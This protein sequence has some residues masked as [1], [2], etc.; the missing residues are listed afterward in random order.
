MRS[1]FLTG[2]SGVGKSTL[3]I[4]ALSQMYQKKH[5]PISGYLTYRCFLKEAV[6]GY[7]IYS[8]SKYIET[9]NPLYPL[10]IR[11]RET[12]ELEEREKYM[13]FQIH[14][15]GVHFSIENFR[16]HTDPLIE[17][18]GDIL[19]LDEVGGM[20]FLDDRFLGK[21]FEQGKNKKIIGIYKEIRNIEV[22]AEKRKLTTEEKFRLIKNRRQ[23]EKRYTKEICR[24]EERDT[25]DCLKRIKSLLEI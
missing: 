1:I 24:V 20:D 6:W 12:P 18:S 14:Q 13:I 25:H 4:R 23:F 16:K 22:F 15:N 7:G 17:A 21:I 5:S 9:G 19:V 10:V 11:F 3:I 8:A 2:E